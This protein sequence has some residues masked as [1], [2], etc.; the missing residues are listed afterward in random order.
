M[1][2]DERVSGSADVS[3]LVSEIREIAVELRQGMEQDRR[4]R[5]ALLSGE[6]ATDA[7]RED[8]I[9]DLNVAFFDAMMSL[10]HDW[11]LPNTEEWKPNGLHE[12]H[13]AVTKAWQDLVDFARSQPVSTDAERER[14]IEAWRER[15][16]FDGID[17]PE[18]GDEG[19]WVSRATVDEAVAL[20]RSRPAPDRPDSDRIRDLK[21]RADVEKTAREK[22]EA[23]N[24][25]LRKQVEEAKA[26]RDHHEERAGKDGCVP[27]NCSQR[28]LPPLPPKDREGDDVLR[29]VWAAWL[30]TMQIE[31]MRTALRESWIGKKVRRALG[32]GGA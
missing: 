31:G 22:V 11:A 7:E 9:G 14:E 30:G 1:V 17:H 28:P 20:M 16:T 23:E 4:D 29:E 2:N 10:T 5:G 21:Q 12:K 25:D 13:A 8:R 6:K 18:M 19:F 32:E 15:A 3:G 26:E 27:G 24:A